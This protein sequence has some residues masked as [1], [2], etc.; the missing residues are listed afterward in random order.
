VSQVIK[1]H[2]K[3]FTEHEVGLYL[4]FRCYDQDWNNLHTNRYEIKFILE[5][6]NFYTEVC[7]IQPDLGTVVRTKFKAK[8][9]TAA[10]QMID[11][12][13]VVKYKIGFVTPLRKRSPK[14][15]KRRSKRRSNKRR[16]V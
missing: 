12:K 2:E 6:T 9:M 5:N 13:Y 16:S 10:L 14:R 15:S 11:P 3:E 7:T 8:E 4:G 1:Q